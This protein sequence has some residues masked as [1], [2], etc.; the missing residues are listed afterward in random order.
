VVGKALISMLA[1]YKQRDFRVKE[2]NGDGEFESLRAIVADGHAA[3]NIISEDK[4]V[5]KS[6][7][8]FGP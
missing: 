5:P 7:D 1:F 8:T 3:L 4:H 2:C 6:S